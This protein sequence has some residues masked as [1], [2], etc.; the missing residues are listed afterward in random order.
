MIKLKFNQITVNQ[1]Y[2]CKNPETGKSLWDEAY[3]EYVTEIIKNPLFGGVYKYLPTEDAVIKNKLIL[4]YKQPFVF[5]RAT[6]PEGRVYTLEDIANMT[7]A[8]RD[9]LPFYEM[10][11]EEA[12]F[13]LDK[14][15]AKTLP[16]DDVARVYHRESDFKRDCINVP[17]AEIVE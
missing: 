5:D 6:T 2:I 4:K 13:Y 1:K 16:R 15:H 10:T 12:A 8:Q 17:L 9:A 14:K 3:E 11:E 7:D